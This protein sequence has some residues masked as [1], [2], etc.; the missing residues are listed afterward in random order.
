MEL[1]KLNGYTF[2]QL[3]VGMNAL[4][5]RTITDT[6]LRN[7]S[8]VCGDTNPMHLNE[9]YAGSTVFGRCVVHGMLTA[10]LLST[11]IGTRLP[12]PGCLYVSQT[13]H[14]R[15]PVYV[16][17]TVYARAT[18]QE[19]IPEKR[20]AIL[21]TECLVRDKIVLDGEAIAQLPKVAG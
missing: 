1:D 16:G 11:V 4:Y 19:L 18:I 5:S 3:S 14:F 9:E 17:D 6:D 15:A 13:L 20:R 2:E 7:F 12:G 21:R 10:S 8:G